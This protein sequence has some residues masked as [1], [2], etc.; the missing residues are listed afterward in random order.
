MIKPIERFEKKECSLVSKCLSTEYIK[1]RR[2][3]CADLINDKSL[4]TLPISNRE[5]EILPSTF[6][7]RDSNETLYD[8]AVMIGILTSSHSR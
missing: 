8:S 1:R 6:S 5:L 2:S 3:N 7:H 4:R